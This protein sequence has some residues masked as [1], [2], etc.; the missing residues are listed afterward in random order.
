MLHE[1]TRA[2]A[3]NTSIISGHRYL[4]TIAQAS[5]CNGC[6]MSQ[7]PDQAA[8]PDPS[9][10][11]Y[12]QSDQAAGPCQATAPI[13]PEGCAPL[14]P[15][16]SP[17]AKAASPL[18]AAALDPHGGAP[19]TPPVPTTAEMLNPY[20]VPA[21]AALAGSR[22]QYRDI[23]LRNCDAYMVYGT[24][25]YIDQPGQSAWQPAA[26]PGSA[27]EDSASQAAYFRSRIRVG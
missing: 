11:L 16:V 12:H 26:P 18:Q 24:C 27:I 20:G 9:C 21:Y 25:R 15:P 3:S 1:A 19:F 6:A 23:R 4:A 2:T 22:C 10:D 13:I 5:I 14:T 17:A 8:S 7:S